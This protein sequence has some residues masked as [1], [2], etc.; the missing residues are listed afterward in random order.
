LEDETR[1]G[2]LRESQKLQSFATLNRGNLHDFRKA[3]KQ[4]R[5]VLQML[6]PHDE[7][8]VKALTDMQT[9]IGEWHDWEELLAIA[10]QILSHGDKCELLRE[11][12]L[13]ADESF[14]AALK[15]ANAVRRRYFNSGPKTAPLRIVAR[16]A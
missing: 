7:S 8:L 5:Y 11:L 12:Q 10:R 4:L 15:N 3:G 9:A 6:K 16:A 13:H 14:D 2:V 1:S